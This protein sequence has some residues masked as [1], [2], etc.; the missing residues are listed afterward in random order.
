M[1]SKNELIDPDE[2]IKT[3]DINISKIE[4]IDNNKIEDIDINKIE[5]IDINKI[6]DID[7]TILILQLKL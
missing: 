5:D 2:D 1:L 3:E 6:E 7:T 4:G